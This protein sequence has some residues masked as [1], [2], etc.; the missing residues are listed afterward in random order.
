MKILMMKRSLIKM[1]VRRLNKKYTDTK[2][3]NESLLRESDRSFKEKV[4]W[5]I[6]LALRLLGN[7][8]KS[9]IKRND[10]SYALGLIE[11]VQE[12]LRDTLGDI[13]EV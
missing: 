7:D 13:D 6:S 2:T 4:D 1:A 11:R 3:T 9:A 8:I 10:T 12:V 5:N